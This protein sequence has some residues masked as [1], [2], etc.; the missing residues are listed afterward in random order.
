MPDLD[1]IDLPDIE[2]FELPKELTDILDVDVDPSS[3]GGP[4]TGILT[5]IILQ[6]YGLKRCVG[7]G[8]E[9]PGRRLSGERQ[10]PGYGGETA[11]FFGGQDIDEVFIEAN[12][13]DG[14]IDLDADGI[15]D[16][17]FFRVTEAIEL[18]SDINFLEFSS[19][20]AST[21][22]KKAKLKEKKAEFKANMASMKETDESP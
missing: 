15:G 7:F 5:G 6:L 14:F 10:L 18:L 3:G 17:S 4:L 2:S 9:G 19:Q 16:F 8:I 13:D 20:S 21:E 1:G 11:C 12:F 22:E